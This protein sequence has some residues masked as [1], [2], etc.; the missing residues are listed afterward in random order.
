MRA[1]TE[2]KAALVTGGAVR[3]GRAIA[4]SLARAGYDVAVHYNRSEAEALATAEEIRGHGVRCE[5]LPHDLSQTA[6][7]DALIGKAMEALPHLNVLI[8][9]A[10]AYDAATIGETTPEQLD[11]LWSVNFKAP[12]FLT[13][14]F[15]K[16][17]EQGSIV[18][19]LDN[20]IAFNQF[21]YAAYLGSKKALAD[22]TKMA[23]LEFAP[24]IRVNGVSPG[25]V[26]PASTRS[27]EY[28][29]WRR[30]AIPVAEVGHPDHVCEAIAYILANRFLTGQTLF[31]DGGEAINVVGRNLT[32]SPVAA[33]S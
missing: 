30:Q 26:L 28:L 19:I 16:R 12:F 13:Q 25:V 8:N 2:K 33:N 11:W 18:N 22:F 3:L 5:L 14:A 15:C 29:Q 31:V 9:S 32:T 10:S 1:V 21:H 17:V 20:K 27:E 23:A 24:G 6:G 7:L 4:V